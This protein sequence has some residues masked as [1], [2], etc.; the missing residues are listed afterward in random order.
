[1]KLCSKCALQKPVADFYASKT[2]KD[3]LYGRCKACHLKMC[4][5]WAQANKAKRNA[6]A[7]EWRRL[8]P[9]KAKAIQQKAKKKAYDA[10]PQK[11]RDLSRK[12][13]AAADKNA[14]SEYHAQYREANADKKRVYAK[15]YYAA[16]TELIKQR[17]AVRS[18]RVQVA[19][20]PRNCER[21]RRYT[22]KKLQAVPPW[23]DIAGIRLIYDRCAEVTA[24][25]GIVHHVDHI[26]PLQS[27][28]VCGL[29]V[30]HNLQIL[31][32]SKNQ[33]KGNRVWPDCP[34]VLPYTKPQRRKR[35]DNT[36]SM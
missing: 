30:D 21:Q 32:A 6:Q 17:V 34:D 15:E 33:S 25:T 1:M 22:A 23:A 11:Y 20:R 26:V 5:E 7:A 24:A 2:T 31:P 27:K 9:E 3:G 18:K 8:N 13:Y 12:N 10:D 4:A 35:S 36:V 29:H 16:N 19:E 28:F 14:M